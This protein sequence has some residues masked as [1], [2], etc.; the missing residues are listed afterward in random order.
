MLRMPYG[1]K[2]RLFSP[3]SLHRYGLLELMYRRGRIWQVPGPSSSQ[4]MKKSKVMAAMISVLGGSGLDGGLYYRSWRMARAAPKVFPSRA[5]PFRFLGGLWDLPFAYTEGWRAC[6][7]VGPSQVSLL[8]G[9]HAAY[10]RLHPHLRTT[11]RIHNPVPL[12]SNSIAWPQCRQLPRP[13]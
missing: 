1:L 12:S 6:V 13:R 10:S 11:L 4:M 9:I 3:G 8:L 7:A 2:P 5:K